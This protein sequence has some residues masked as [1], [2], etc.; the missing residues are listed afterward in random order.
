MAQ[1]RTPQ[2]HFEGRRKQS[3]E[4][5]GRNLGEK[6]EKEGNGGT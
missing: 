4:E 1:L 6:E 3:Q 2:S 5:G